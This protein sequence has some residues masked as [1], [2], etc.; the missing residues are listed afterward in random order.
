MVGA[1]FAFSWSR[2]RFVFLERER[3]EGERRHSTSNARRF[4]EKS[5]K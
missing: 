5:T 4:E 2:L 1:V 3:R